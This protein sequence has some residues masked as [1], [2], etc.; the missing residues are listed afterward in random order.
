MIVDCGKRIKIIDFGLCRTLDN[1]ELKSKSTTVKNW[2]PN[3]MSPESMDRRIIYGCGT[4]IW[5]LIVNEKFSGDVP[6]EGF[7]LTQIAMHLGH[8][9][10]ILFHSGIR[11]RL[12][13]LLKSEMCFSPELAKTDEISSQ[14]LIS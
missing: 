9:K 6:F 10:P 4:W 11:G 8:R 2:T 12:R 7:A 1:A 14:A 13:T 5:A 3:Y